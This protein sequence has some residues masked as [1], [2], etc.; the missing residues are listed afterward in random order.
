MRQGGGKR[1]AIHRLVFKQGILL[2]R[3]L[4]EGVGFEPT[5]ALASPGDFQDPCLKPL[6]H[7]SGGL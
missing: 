4:A 5:R 2:R 6:G 3:R 1:F 7:P